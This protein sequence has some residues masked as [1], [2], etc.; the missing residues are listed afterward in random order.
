LQITIVRRTQ[1]SQP[2]EYLVYRSLQLGISALG[3]RSRWLTTIITLETEIANV[4]VRLAKTAA[5]MVGRKVPMSPQ[6][7]RSVS[8]GSLVIISSRIVVS[9]SRPGTVLK[10]NVTR[11]CTDTAGPRP[12]QRIDMTLR[13]EPILWH[14]NRGARNRCKR[15]WSTIEG[16]RVSC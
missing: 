16:F 4:F 10:P 1:D 6:D 5:R 13:N 9:G 3:K 2:L 15:F 8:S 7:P 14:S 11:S 12:N